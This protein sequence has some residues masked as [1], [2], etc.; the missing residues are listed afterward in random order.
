M[1]NWKKLIVS[2]SDAALQSLNV[3]SEFTASGLNYPTSDGTGGQVL[4]TDGSGNLSF[5]IPDAEKLTFEVQNGDSFPLPKGTPIHIS[6]STNGTS[7]VIAAS[8]SDAST[9][10]AHGVLN[11]SLIPDSDGFATIIGNINGVDTSAFN[12]GDTI[13]VGANGGY[14]NVKPTGDSNLVQNLGVVRKVD[15]TNGSGEIFGAG[16]SNDVPNLPE[17]KIWVGSSTYSVTSS[18]AHLDETNERLGINTNTPGASL[19][20]IGDISGSTKLTIGSSHINTG[21]LSSI[22]G[23]CENTVL[24]TCGFIGG[25]RCNYVGTNVDT[26]P[27]VIGGGAS[28]C[29]TAY[30]TSGIF[31][32]NSNVVAPGYINGNIFIVGG[33]NNKITSSIDHGCMGASFIGSGCFN[34]ICSCGNSSTI[35]GGCGNIISNHCSII[36]GGES[37]CI[38]AACSFIGGGWTNNITS[39]AGSGFLGGGNGNTLCSA[40]G[41]LVGGC[42]N[43][44]EGWGAVTLVGGD[45]NTASGCCAFLGGGSRNTVAGTTSTLVGGW[46]NCINSNISFIGGGCLNTASADYSFIGGGARN[47]MNTSAVSSS[48][49]GGFDNTTNLQNTHII[50]SNLTADKANYTYVNNLDVEGTVSGSVFS[51]SFVGNGSG[52]T[53]IPAGSVGAAGSNTQI[54]FN[55]GGNLGANTNF[56]FDGNTVFVDGNIQIEQQTLTDA[57]TVS[58]N[59]D[60][61]SNAKITLGGNRTLSISNAGV[62]DTGTILVQQGSGTTHTLTLPGGSIVIGGATYTTTT[63]SNGVDVL[64]F[65]YDGTNYYWSIP[66]TATSGPAGPAGPTGPSGVPSI[67]GN[68]DNRVLTATGTSTINGEGNLTF[69]GS[70]LT[71]GSKAT[72]GSNHINT[73]TLSSIVGG[74]LNTASGD[75]SFIGGGENNIV[76]DVHST[77]GGGINNTLNGSFSGILGGREN[78]ITHND[79]FA[80]GAFLTSSK[81]NYAY[82]NNICLLV[83]S[84]EYSLYRSGSNADI[85]LL[86]GFQPTTSGSAVVYKNNAD[87][88]EGIASYHLANSTVLWEQGYSTGS[89]G[90]FTIDVRNN[91]EPVPTGTT[92]FKIKSGYTG[93]KFSITQDGGGSCATPGVGN[94]DVGPSFNF[95]NNS[96]SNGSNALAIGAATTAWG[97]SSFATGILTLAEGQGSAA[98]NLLNEAIGGSSVAFGNKTKACGQFSAT[99]GQDSIAGGIN[100]LT[101]GEK[102]IA[103]GSRSFASGFCTRACNNNAVSFGF[104]TQA[105]GPNSFAGGYQSEASNSTFSSFSFGECTRATGINSVAFGKNT[106]ASGNNA[107]TLNTNSTASSANSTAIAGG[108]AAA[109]QTFA[110]IGTACSFR[111]VAFQASTAAAPCSFAAGDN[112]RTDASQAVVFGKNNCTRGTQGLTAGL[113]NDNCT[114]N[115]AMFGK[116]NVSCGFYGNSIIGGSCNTSAE[117]N[118]LVMGQCNIASQPHQTVLGQYAD[119]TR[120]NSIFVVGVGASAASRANALEVVDTATPRIIMQG[121]KDSPSYANDSAAGTGGVPVGGLYRNGNVVQIRLS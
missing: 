92:L 31:G 32:G 29:V 73:G 42:N 80:I 36:G 41:V 100:S 16:R 97:D 13:Y 7:I 20:V 18:V 43:N 5:D 86:Q 1:P 62:G 93:N 106:L 46:N 56:T 27:H 60:N 84:G 39:F 63:T 117:R 33:Y 25:G 14:T 65:Y 10:P 107:I 28:N 47:Y 91:N 64:G 40:V 77:I 44:V 58:W 66:Q 112:N 99:F 61:G 83:N 75:C 24:G 109:D 104:N 68:V 85:S 108:N 9:M 55:D 17:G 30:N 94:V 35:V 114:N 50:G 4:V 23:G 67:T 6:S 48:I 45:G 49:V 70:T 21:T 37:N 3:T 103:S 12:V 95:G 79:S 113:N 118:Q 82:M 105:L 102:G 87:N 88:L 74:T 38:T 11:Q 22:A 101:I 59:L 57:A 98:F 69:D 34:K 76:S 89:Q 110:H 116:D 78:T 15:A 71:V 51:G 2:G 96:Y 72:I 19:D 120:T 81:D 115:T 8:A 53:G 121:L 26:A 111:A 90:V 52:L 119:A 54:Q